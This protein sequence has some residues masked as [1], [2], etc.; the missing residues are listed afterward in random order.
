M[1]KAMQELLQKELLVPKGRLKVE[2]SLD[3][4]RYGYA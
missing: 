4:R 1:L 2:A 3:A